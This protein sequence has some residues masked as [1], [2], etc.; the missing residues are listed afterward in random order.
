MLLFRKHNQFETEN[1]LHEKAIHPILFSIMHNIFHICLFFN[2][3]EPYRL[4]KCTVYNRF[5]KCCHYITKT[6]AENQ[7]LMMPGTT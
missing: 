6:E 3:G 7:F 4:D 5:N 1:L 2:E